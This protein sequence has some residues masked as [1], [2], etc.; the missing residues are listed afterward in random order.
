MR[1]ALA[2]ALQVQMQTNFDHDPMSQMQLPKL[3]AQ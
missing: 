2:E 3:E 1:Q